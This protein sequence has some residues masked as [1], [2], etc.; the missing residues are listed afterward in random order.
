MVNIL[1]IDRVVEATEDF[2][3][4][5]NLGTD[6]EKTGILSRFRNAYNV[7]ADG[8]G[9]VE[10]GAGADSVAQATEQGVHT[11]SAGDGARGGTVAFSDIFSGTQ[12]V[13]RLG[14]DEDKIGKLNSNV[15]AIMRSGSVTLNG[16]EDIE[17]FYGICNR[18]GP[19]LTEIDP[20]KFE[21]LIQNDDIMDNQ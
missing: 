4:Y 13:E 12:L 2:N 7:T 1:E 14:G 11:I 21:V 6:A 5:R 9:I 18:L 16:D 19:I 20:Q 3:E 8:R 10:G 15:N 17:R